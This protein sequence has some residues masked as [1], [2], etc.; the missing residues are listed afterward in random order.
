MTRKADDYQARAR[1]IQAAADGDA[2]DLPGL[3]RR[4]CATPTRCRSRAPRSWWGS[5]C[6]MTWSRT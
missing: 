1:Q 5:A 4:P 3:I 2:Q 6:S